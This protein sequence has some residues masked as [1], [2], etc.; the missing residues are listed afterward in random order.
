MSGLLLKG[1]NKI[2]PGGNQAVFNFCLD[3]RDKEFVVFVG[4]SGCGKSTTLR[5]I[6]GLEEIS[7][8]ELYID[9]KLV[10]DVVPKDR[11]IAMVFQNYALYPHMS[12]YDNMAFGLKLRKVPKDVIDEKVKAAAEILGITDYLSRKPKALSGGQRQRVALGR[13]IVREPK[14]FL[15]DEPLSNLDAKL[16]AQMRTEISK[17]HVRLATT[18]IYVTHDQIEAMTMGTRIVVMKDGFMQQVDTPQNLYDYPINQ[19]VAGFIGTPQMNFFPATLTKSKNKVYVEFVNNNKILLPKTVEA[20]IR[21]INDYVNTGKP[22]VLGVRPEDI[23]EEESFI[24]A[25]PDT[26]VKAFVEVVEKLGAETLIYSKLDF[27]EGEDAENATESIADSS[28]MVAKID[29]RSIVNRGEVIELA[30]DARH[31]HL[32]DGATEMSILARDEGYEVTAENESSSNFVPLTPQEMQAIIEKNRVVTKEEKAAMR[33][34]A[35][36]AAKKEKAEAKA[37]AEALAEAP[38]EDAENAENAEDENKEE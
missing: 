3:I 23:H 25:S 36:A 27:K 7:S 13:T 8:G 29:S 24:S 38:A 17:L 37:A 22:I 21:N 15:L 33:R 14:V 34:E 5:M 16:R 35:R 6:A 2:Y 28:Y 18:F 20:R 31:I 26:V 32:F 9:G 10:N 30:M 12:V 4:P 11:D 1:I 19:F